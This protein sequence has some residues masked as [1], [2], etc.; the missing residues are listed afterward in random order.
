MINGIL[1][2]EIIIG[3]ILG[4]VLLS[5]LGFVLSRKIEKDEDFTKRI[6]KRFILKYIILLML[7]TGIIFL[8]VS[9]IL[10]FKFVEIGQYLIFGSYIF[11]IVSVIW[12]YAFVEIIYRILNIQR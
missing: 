2:N 10:A 6:N 4:F 11:I 12:V 7:I 1:S 9:F 8:I 3:T 5:F